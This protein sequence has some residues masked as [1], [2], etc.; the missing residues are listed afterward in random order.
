MLQALWAG[1]DDVESE[2]NEG[3]A[4]PEADYDSNVSEGKG[5]GG[6]G[7]AG[8]AGGAG[9]PEWAMTGVKT[10]CIA[11]NGCGLEWALGQSRM[12]PEWLLNGPAMAGPP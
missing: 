6:A 12:A 8:G 3:F 1:L 5:P 4:A 9:L 10:A 11:M 7:R 2:E